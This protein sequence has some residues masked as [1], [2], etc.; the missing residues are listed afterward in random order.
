MKGLVEHGCCPKI[1]TV[2][3]DFNVN[4]GKSTIGN[5][6]LRAY[7]SENGIR[8]TDF[9]A[10]QKKMIVVGTTF[11]YKDIHRTTCVIS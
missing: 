8:L 1:K 2:V 10:K 5:F 9:G 4:I 6:S 7:T 3:G 11:E